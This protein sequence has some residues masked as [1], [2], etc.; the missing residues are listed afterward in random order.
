[1]VVGVEKGCGG[2]WGGMVRVEVVEDGVW[3]GGMG[4]V[5]VGYSGI[6]GLMA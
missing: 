2:D 4:V 3:W 1:M 5:G 6:D